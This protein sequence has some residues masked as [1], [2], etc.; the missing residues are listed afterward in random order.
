[1]AGRQ[2]D[3]PGFNRAVLAQRPIGSLI[4]PLLLYSL[5][6]QGNTLA[7]LVNDKPVR[8][9]QSNNVIWQPQNY[10]LKIHGEMSLYQ[11]FIRSYNLPFVQLGVNGGLELLANNLTKINLL[12]R[13][14]IYPS[15]LLGTSE[16]S[17]FEVAQMFQVGDPK[18]SATLLT[19]RV[20]EL[21]SFE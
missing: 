5:L 14:I 7:T 18:G 15:L 2:A 16:M 9:R 21:D 12:K 20:D 3:F 10:D 6:E 11:A 1:M 19:K 17:A 8:I 4:K 13:N